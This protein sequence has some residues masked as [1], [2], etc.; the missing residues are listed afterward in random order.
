MRM[1]VAGSCVW[2]NIR[3]SGLHIFSPKASNSKSTL[4]W[5]TIFYRIRLPCRRGRDRDIKRSKSD[6][7]V[8]YSPTRILI[9]H[10]DFF[11]FG[12]YL[13][14]KKNNCESILSPKCV[15]SIVCNCRTHLE[16][17]I[18]ISMSLLMYF[19]F[20]WR[21]RLWFCWSPQ[22]KKIDFDWLIEIIAYYVKFI[23]P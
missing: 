2:W 20:L 23:A 19:L 22:Y 16:R 8:R 1:P 6:K 17:M 13:N 12:K 18:S 3:H 11:S 15:R 5:E 9:R 4:T 14:Y 21:V 7:F 10:S